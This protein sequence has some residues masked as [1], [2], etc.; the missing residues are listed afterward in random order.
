MGLCTE[1]L[2]WEKELKWPGTVLPRL[3]AAMPNAAGRRSHLLC[4]GVQGWKRPTSCLY[5]GGDL[6]S[7]VLRLQVVFLPCLH[8]VSSSEV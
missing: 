1:S 2:V 6:G 8:L 4:T 7:L 5:G 3:A